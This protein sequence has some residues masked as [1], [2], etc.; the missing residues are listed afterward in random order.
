MRKETI[1]KDIEKEFKTRVLSLLEEVDN[2]KAGSDEQKNLVE[3]ATKC[4]DEYLKY[5][6]GEDE[7][8]NNDA[9]RQKAYAEVEKL[10]AEVEKLSEEPGFDLKKWIMQIRPDQVA[11]TVVILA[12]TAAAF[13]MEKNGCIF[14]ERLIKWPMKLLGK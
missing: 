10:K 9:T 14:P 3:E 5:L 1:M 11:N 8:F 2:A 4:A 12:V 13:R 7:I 6:K